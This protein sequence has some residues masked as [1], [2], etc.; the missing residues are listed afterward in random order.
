MGKGIVKVGCPW[1]AESLESEMRGKENSLDTVVSAKRK[2]KGD[3][4]KKL[5]EG[6]RQRCELKSETFDSDPAGVNPVWQRLTN[7]QKRVL[8]WDR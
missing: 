4:A 5:G 8:R 2:V 3:C 6:G 7:G 1:S